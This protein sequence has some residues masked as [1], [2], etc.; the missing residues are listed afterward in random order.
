MTSIIKVDQIQLADGST[1]NAQDLGLAAGSVIQVVTSTYAT[2]TSS[3]ASS[4]TDTGLSASITPSNT[5]NKI[6]VLCNLCSAGVQQTGGNDANGKFKL[7]RGGT[8]LYE[9]IH[10]SYDYGGSGQITFGSYLMSWLDSPS[11][12]SSTTY[13][14]Q[15]Q[16]AAGT[17]IRICESNNTCL[18]YTSPSPR[19]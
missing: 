3:G 7:V 11:T 1:P 12:T 18:L 14:L 17:S 2:E 16:L 10:R 8:D 9:S 13:K 5:S 4:Y 15:Q 19:D 6:L